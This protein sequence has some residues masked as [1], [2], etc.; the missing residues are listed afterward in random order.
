M[1]F[2]DTST[3][4]LAIS[5]AAAEMRAA[6]MDAENHWE[7]VLRSSAFDRC[8][9]TILAERPQ[10]RRGSTRRFA[11]DNNA[12]PEVSCALSPVM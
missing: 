10:F 2:S 9:A 3:I 7:Y 11:I 6:E 12:D 8:I 4:A 5:V 1:H